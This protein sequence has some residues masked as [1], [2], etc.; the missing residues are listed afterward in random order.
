MTNARLHAIE[1]GPQSAAPVV[2]LHGFGGH[3]QSWQPVLDVLAGQCRTIA[4]DLPGHGGSLDYPGFGS[5]RTAA[6]AVLAELRLGGIDKAHIAGHSMGGAAAVLLAL[7]DPEAIASLTLIAPGGFGPE[8][9]GQALRSLA[10]AGTAEDLSRAYAAMMAPR[11]APEPA[12]IERLLEVHIRT[13]QKE[14]LR[15]I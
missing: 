10:E 1:A 5:P 6:L 13:G 9:D 8:M 7:A 3:G 12:M 14:A 11:A 4:F 15:Q 2:L